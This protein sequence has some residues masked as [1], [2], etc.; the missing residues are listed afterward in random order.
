MMRHGLT[1]A[2]LVFL[3]DRTSKLAL[4]DLM[5]RQPEGI[6]LTPFL[7]LVQVWNRG[8]SFGFLGAEWLGGNQRWLLALFALAA[9]G[10]MVVWLR[11][12]T[13]RRE[14]L[15]IGLVIGGAIGNAV[16]RMLY[17]AVADFFDFHVAGWHWPSFNLA[18]VAITGGGLALVTLAMAAPNAEAS[19]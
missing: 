14:A 10:A 5:A 2:T 16:D 15:A 1:V 18:D 12:V 13:S 11:R 7:N 6:I 9:A 19:S 3:I 8:V 17:G 4:V